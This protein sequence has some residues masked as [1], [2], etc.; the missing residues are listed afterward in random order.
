[1]TKTEL[2]KELNYV[3]ASREKR[4]YYAELVI[5]NPDLIGPLITIMFEV[6]D[7]VSCKAA[8]VF[9]YVCDEKLEAIIPYLDVFTNNISK[10][11]L[12]SSVRPMAKICEY[13]VK[14]YYGQTDNEIKNHLSEVPKEKIIEACFDWLINDEKIAPKAYAMNTLYLLGNEYD[15]IHPELTIIL[16]RNFKKQSAGFKARA[17]HILRKIQK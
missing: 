12:D 5:A 9:E 3:D 2:Y 7:K 11:H 17:R 1:L 8:W 4:L 14:A 15:W 10:V 16:E 6:N 13:I